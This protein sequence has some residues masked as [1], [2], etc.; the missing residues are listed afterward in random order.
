MHG[1]L[2]LLACCVAAL[3]WGVARGDAIY[4]M[5][6]QDS[7]YEPFEFAYAQMIDADDGHVYGLANQQTAAEVVPKVE[8]VDAVEG[9]HG[10]AID[11]T[12]TYIG[13]ED[14]WKDRSFYIELYRLN[15]EDV[16]VAGRSVVFSFADCST[17]DH[18]HIWT[19]GSGLQ[20]SQ[21]TALAI[22]VP[23]PTG[24]MLVL[25]GL[26]A[27]ALRRRGKRS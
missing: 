3:G 10:A 21:V 22:V 1:V 15:G 13:A 5:L 17:D 20:P 24:G 2:R 8:L 11:K 9:W 7:R 14:D 18:N 27:L 26:A 16:E 25:L 12:A 19:V 23:E 6:Y 4:W